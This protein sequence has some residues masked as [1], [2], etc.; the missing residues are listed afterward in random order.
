MHAEENVIQKF[1][2]HPLLFLGFY[3][4][5][6][7]LSFM[8][9]FIFDSIPFLAQDFDPL[10]PKILF[11]VGIAV[12]VLGEVSRRAETFYITD[13]GVAQEYKFL[14]THR[15][16]AEYRRLQNIEVRQSFFERIFSIGNIYF[17]TAGVD[18]T[19]VN[20]RGVNY[21]YRIEK[22]VRE[23]MASAG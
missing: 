16:F 3:L 2:P 11:W 12:I 21:P 15:K 8:S 14:T 17:D 20:F 13:S 22:I 6:L 23:K 10:V 19:E 4:G 1:H 18:K 9:S 7:A 5:G